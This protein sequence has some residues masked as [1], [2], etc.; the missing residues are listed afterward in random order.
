MEFEHFAPA[1][2]FF[3]LACIFLG[4]ALGFILGHFRRKAPLRSRNRSLTLAFCFLSVMVIFLAAALIYSKGQVFTEPPVYITG[5]VFVVFLVLVVRFPKAAGFPFILLAVVAAIWA[6]LSFFRYPIAR[7]SAPVA[8][9]TNEDLGSDLELVYT[10]LRAPRFYPLM[11]GETRGLLKDAK[12]RGMP[13]MAPD[14]LRII[15]PAASGFS[16]TVKV[17]IEDDELV[18]KQTLN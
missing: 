5:A 7:P 9:Y 1:R 4:A 3:Y 11:G 14:R 18:I 2:D 16:G 10:R 17:Y 13:G 12:L 8:S 15:V 6:G